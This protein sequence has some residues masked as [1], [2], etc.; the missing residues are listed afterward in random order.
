MANYDSP[1]VPLDNPKDRSTR[2]LYVGDHGSGKTSLINTYVTK[3]WSSVPTNL[4]MGVTN[5][6]DSNL[7]VGVPISGFT[8]VIVPAK[9]NGI[10]YTDVHLCDSS[11]DENLHESTIFTPIEKGH[12]DVV[13]IC[14]DREENLSRVCEYWLHNILERIQ[15]IP[16]SC[17][18]SKR[19]HLGHRAR[20]VP[21][22][23]VQN[24]CDLGEHTDDVYSMVY[25]KYPEV[26]EVDDYHTV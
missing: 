2:I 16:Q 9:F 5:K 25:E 12:I 14:Y 23:L 13:V 17:W 11:S 26:I 21:I 18:A 4:S 8:E 20:T 7:Q 10:D 1:K 15:R 24:K 19:V 3:S 6:L 22:M